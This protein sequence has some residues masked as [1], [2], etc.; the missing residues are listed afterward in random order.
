MHEVSQLV[1]DYISQVIAGGGE[2]HEEKRT[3]E[4]P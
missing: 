2:K 3:L 1:F 4:H